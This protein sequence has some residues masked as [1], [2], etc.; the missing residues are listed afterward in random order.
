VQLTNGALGEA[1]G[2]LYVARFFPPAAKAQ[3]QELIENL[4]GS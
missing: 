1:V 4:R 3:M 2:E